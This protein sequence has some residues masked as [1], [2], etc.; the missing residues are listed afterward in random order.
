MK[1][2]A[3][4]S[5][6]LR[7]L[8]ERAEITTR[9][10]ARQLN[11]HHTNIVYWEKTGRVAKVELLPKMAEILGVSVEE[12][13]GQPRPKRNPIAPGKLGQ[14]FEAASELPRRQQQKIID[15]VEPFIISYHREHEE[16][17]SS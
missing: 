6:P 17:S 5:S 15:F 16:V 1:T 8:R 13:L 14:V 10:L 3:L 7:E 12:I 4:P 9:E 11:I 2:E